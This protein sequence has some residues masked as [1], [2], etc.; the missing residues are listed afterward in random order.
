M[1]RGLSRPGLLAGLAYLGFAGLGVRS[2]L[3]GVSWPSIRADFDMP[4]DALGALLGPYAIG[5]MLASFVTG[6]V[7][8]RWNLGIV[9]AASAAGMAVNLLGSALAP[10]WWRLLAV[11]LPG[12]LGTGLID[13][14]LNTYVA[15]RQGPREMNWLH[16]SWGVGVTLSPLMMTA[17]I[18]SGLGWRWGYALSGFLLL[19]LSGGYVASSRLWPSRADVTQMDSGGGAST[20]TASM[21]LTLRLP[22]AWLSMLLFIVYTGVEVGIG[23]WAFALLVDARGMGTLEAGAAVSAYWAGLTLGRLFFGVVVAAIG[24]E[25]LLRLC[26]LSVLLG[27]GVLWLPAPSG[28]AFGVLALLGAAQ[29]P[30]FPA[31]VTVTPDRFGGV[32]TAN[33]VGFQVAASVVGGT[34]L[35]A[36]LGVLAQAFGLQVIVP[37]LLVAAVIQIVCYL[38]W[39]SNH[40]S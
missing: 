27:L 24:V 39:S 1:R 34:G 18:T 13:A 20:R 38:A 14:G 9:L 30:V 17:A 5:Y 3:L 6:R 7:L 40:L 36:L 12:G 15:N 28:L 10:A 16:A 23:Q 2:G 11:G 4:L 22:V 19:A 29:A 32:H 8:V 21:W 25:R 26:L 33:A 37:T 35:P 31:L